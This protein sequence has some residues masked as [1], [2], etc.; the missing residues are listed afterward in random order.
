VGDDPVLPPE[1]MHTETHSGHGGSAATGG[2]S[3]TNNITNFGK[4]GMVVLVVCIGLALG[5]AIGAVVMQAWGQQIQREHA[6]IQIENAKEQ[7][8]IRI[9]AAEKRATDM[10]WLAKQEARLAAQ[11]VIDLKE[12]LRKNGILNK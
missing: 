8:Q 6:A 2:T 3:I 4:A 9:E 12:E 11:D 10:A 5:L 1:L 7:A